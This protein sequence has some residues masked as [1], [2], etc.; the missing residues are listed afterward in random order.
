[1]PFGYPT[2]TS[3]SNPNTRVATVGGGGNKIGPAIV[4]KVMAGDKFSLK[5][6]D[7][8]NKGHN[9][10]G[11]PS[12]PVS[13]LLTA[14]T[15]SIGSVATGHATTSELQ[16][17]SILNP[18]AQAFYLSQVTKVLGTIYHDVLRATDD[19]QVRGSWNA[20]INK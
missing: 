13:D 15:G 11:T 3:Y 20:T 4:L 17:N 5:V 18:G 12:N 10:P 7:W 19:L 16:T 14:L 2:D 1:L 6:S 9:F 8:Y